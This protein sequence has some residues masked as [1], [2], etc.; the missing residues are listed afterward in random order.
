MSE[1]HKGE[2]STL[3]I[4]SVAGGF[5]VSWDVPDPS[6]HYALMQQQGA[7]AG[8]YTQQAMKSVE[9]VCSGLP[10]LLALIGETIRVVP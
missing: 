4:R 9:R 1:P 6:G 7:L 10:A 5:I 2:V 8:G 3:T